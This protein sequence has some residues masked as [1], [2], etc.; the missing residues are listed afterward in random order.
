[1]QIAASASG[2]SSSVANSDGVKNKNITAQGRVAFRAE[3]SMHCASFVIIIAEQERLLR[4]GLSSR[5]I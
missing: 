5:T 1:M 3:I 4:V 2:L